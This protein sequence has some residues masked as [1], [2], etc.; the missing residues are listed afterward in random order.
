MAQPCGAR[1][2]SPVWF[3]PCASH[4][5]P[6]FCQVWT[7]HNRVAL[8]VSVTERGVPIGDSAKADRLQET[9]RGMLG[10][11]DAVVKMEMVRGDIHHERRLH[12][13]LLLEEL[14]S[15]E[16]QQGAASQQVGGLY[17][18]LSK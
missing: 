14:R 9:L 10:G 16:E 17:E 2:S 12:H 11:E 3:D 4:T 5:F 15:W 18:S 8:V 7:F 1:L 6:H 13:L